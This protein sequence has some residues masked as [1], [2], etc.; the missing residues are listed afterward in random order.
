MVGKSGEI[1]LCM[2]VKNEEEHLS[3]S[4]QA[5]Q[6]FV[7]EIIIVDTG[8]DDRTIEIAKSFGARIYKFD[9]TDDFSA[10]RN[11]A[12]QFATKE[13]VL[14]LD[15]DHFVEHSPTS[16]MRN[17][18][19]N[20]TKLGFFISE[21]SVD[22][23]NKRH[24]LERLLL[25]RNFRGFYYEGAIHEHPGNSIHR[26][27]LENHISEQLGRLNG[28]V[29]LHHGYDDPQKKLARNLK[30]LEKAVKNSPHN[31]HY[32]YKYLLTLQ[33]LKDGNFEPML[34]KAVAL[35]LHA[36]P[37]LR[38]SVIGI[39]GLFGDWVYR[40]NINESE[41]VFLSGA[42]Q[43]G[44]QTEWNDYRLVKPVTRI[45]EKKGDTERALQILRICILKGVAPRYVALTVY[46]R[47][48]A[49]YQVL[50]LHN[51]HSD[52]SAFLDDIHRLDLYLE[53]GGIDAHGFNQYLKETDVALWE[54]LK[55]LSSNRKTNSTVRP[56]LSL[57]MIVKN[58]Q[59]NLEN[60]LQSVSDVCDEIIVIDTGST[61][62]TRAI[63][64]NFTDKIFNHPWDGDFSSARNAAL[65]K[66]TGEWILHLDA[67]ETMTPESAKRLK[68]FLQNCKQDGVN[69]VV[70]N[71]QPEHDMVKYLDE[72][73][74]RIFR[75]KKQHRYENRI[76]EQI[77]P[78]LKR[79]GGKLADSD[80]RIDHFGYM[81]IG[82]GRNE[83]NL[84][85]LNQQLSE[86]PLDS[87]ILF[88]L[89]E[90][91]KAMNDLDKAAQYLSSAI[92]N[93]S[94]NLTNE[95]LETIYL[96]LAQIELARN[97]YL[98]AGSYADGCLR[99]N[100]YN[101]IAI[102]VRGIV[103][104]YL[105]KTDLALKSFTKVKAASGHHSLDLTDMERLMNVLHPTQ[106]TNFLN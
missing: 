13:W 36:N 49:L 24:D 77:V 47:Y 54:T 61:D 2:I 31:F 7:D 5:V 93:A 38:E 15:A 16:D 97:N 86:H 52:V 9:W 11:Y 63:A 37:A 70:R 106:N 104:M 33:G 29:V 58:E 100:E 75:N 67:D 81:S 89:G 79:G 62:K 76:H 6:S 41:A 34:K 43:I 95:I 42:Q 80:L 68:S 26:Y 22:K 57:C 56:L 44:D 35:I 71:Y 64:E 8:S 27:A 10:A 82:A 90:T 19:M 98:E 20:T 48:D 1:S 73:Q 91:H 21:E 83:R 102:Y 99:F 101:Y 94:G 50:R 46:D 84:N 39:W 55:M 65:E 96:R 17:V 28:F 87:Y 60:C 32:Q 69:I 85:L 25:F 23:T 3:D 78:A 4:L 105:G 53:K 59:S 103:D 12:L 72:F 88:K 92:R 40:F 14:N 18:L 66:A 30:I 45:L 51:M 74:V